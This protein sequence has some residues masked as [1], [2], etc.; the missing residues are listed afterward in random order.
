MATIYDS[1]EVLIETER[2]DNYEAK[3]QVNGA[4][5]IWISRADEQEFKRELSDLLDRY[6]I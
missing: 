6:R 2:V 4:L 1:N 5:L 3:V